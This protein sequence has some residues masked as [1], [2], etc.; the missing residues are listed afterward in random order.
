[1]MQVGA[2]QVDPLRLQP[3]GKRLKVLCCVEFKLMESLSLKVNR[4]KMI[5]TTGS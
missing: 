1:M 5:E 2:A 3:Y 4:L